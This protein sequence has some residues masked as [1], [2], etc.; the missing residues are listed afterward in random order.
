M[1][2]ALLPP[3]EEMTLYPL[4]LFETL[5][6]LGYHHWPSDEA[7]LVLEALEALPQ[8]SEALLFDEEDEEE[9]AAGIAYLSVGAPLPGDL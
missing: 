8:W 1:I 7:V 4:H 2:E 9:W 6:A 5:C 3:E